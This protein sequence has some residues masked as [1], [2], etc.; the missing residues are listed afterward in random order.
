[1]FDPHLTLDFLDKWMGQGFNIRTYV[2]PL[3]VAMVAG[4]GGINGC[5][6]LWLTKE[7]E[8]GSMELQN[9]FRA[10]L[11]IT[12]IVNIFVST[13]TVIWVAKKLHEDFRMIISQLLGMCAS[14]ELF[15]GSVQ[16]LLNTCFYNI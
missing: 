13:E 14:F 2:G 12:M 16:V 15:R 6:A 7:F 10:F 9:N 3:F 11:I 5:I 4:A 1:M 8:L